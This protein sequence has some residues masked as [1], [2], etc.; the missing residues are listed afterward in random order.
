MKPLTETKPIELETLLCVHNFCEQNGLKYFLIAGTL[1]GAVRHKGFIPWDDDVD[2]EMPREDYDRFVREFNVA[3]YKVVTHENT[4]NYFYPYAKVFDTRTIL[5]EKMRVKY[6]NGVG[7]DVFPIDSLS[8]N[9]EEDE[10]NWKKIKFYRDIISAK[11]FWLKG[12]NPV[13]R[14][15]A[16]LIAAFFNGKKVAEKITRIASAYK[17]QKTQKSGVAVW[18]YGRDKERFDSDVYSERIL[19][20]FEGHQLYCSKQYDKILTQVYGDYMTPPPVEKRSSTH[21][22]EAYYLED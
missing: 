11:L 22:F 14:C 10:K 2:I 13:K 16:R 18:G 5:D 4:K 12:M 7:I 17:G 8:D 15:C 21:H 19:M 9:F 1:I 6:D 3:N 20:D